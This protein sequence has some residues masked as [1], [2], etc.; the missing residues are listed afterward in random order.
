MSVSYAK[1][2][3]TVRNKVSFVFV[4]FYVEVFIFYVIELVIVFA[5]LAYWPKKEMVILLCLVTMTISS[6][7]SWKS[8][9]KKKNCRMYDKAPLWQFAYS[10]SLPRHSHPMPNFLSWT[11]RHVHTI[12]SLSGTPGILGGRIRGVG[13]RGDV[14][15]GCITGRRERIL[16]LFPP[17]QFHPS[18]DLILMASVERWL[19]SCSFSGLLLIARDSSSQEYRP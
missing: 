8:W 17:K 15:F 6:I 11:G 18:E 9:I 3:N 16:F 4:F 5:Q 19:S 14:L 1:V 2:R 13:G 10:K 12:A 7:K